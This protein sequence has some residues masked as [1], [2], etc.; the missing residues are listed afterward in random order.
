MMI[1]GD[2]DNEVGGT[3]STRGDVINL[4]NM[5]EDAKVNLTAWVDIFKV[6]L[7]VIGCDGDGLGFV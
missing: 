1:S 7:R 3:C 2:I 5:L 4:C 6:Y